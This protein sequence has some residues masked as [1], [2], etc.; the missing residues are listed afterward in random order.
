MVSR[1][2]VN[3]MVRGQWMEAS[4][5]SPLKHRAIK[6]HIVFPAH[7]VVCCRTPVS[8]PL[9]CV[10]PCQ[11]S[12]RLQWYSTPTPSSWQFSNRV[13]TVPLNYIFLSYMCPPQK[14]IYAAF[15]KLKKTKAH[16]WYLITWLIFLIKVNT[17]TYTKVTKCTVTSTQSIQI[18]IVNITHQVEWHFFIPE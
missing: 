9:D 5:P 11:T 10:A 8:P 18:H 2:V 14:I 13:E 4:F 6:A 3:S 1:Q 15:T 17:V 16:A 12:R 7:C